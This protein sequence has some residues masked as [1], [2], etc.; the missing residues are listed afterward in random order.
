MT[1]LAQIVSRRRI[2]GE[3]SDEIQAHLDERIEELISAGMSRADASF[4]ARREF[5]NVTRTKETSSE[6]WRWTHFEDLMQDVR[7]GARMLRKSPGFT[8]IAILTLALGIGASTTVFS[9]VNSILL[10]PLPYPH[11][12]QIV[13]PWRITPPGVDLGFAEFP[14]D[15]TGY[16]LFAKETQTF[17]DT[18]AMEA[19]TFNLTGSGDPVRLN[20]VTVS[21]GF[22]PTLGVAPQVG[23]TF[24][25]DEDQLGH[26]REAVLSDALWR[27]QFG[28][29][30]GIAGRS[31]DLDGLSYAVIGVMPPGFA[32]PRSEEMPG[33]F[34]FPHTPQLWVPI[35]LPTGPPKRGEPSELAVIGRLKPGVSV[36]QAQAEMNIFTK[37]Q[38]ALIPAAKG[39]FN[40]RVTP[41]SRQV[42][43]DT[44]RPLLLILGA[45]GV[46]LLI[47][48]S[49]VAS[50]LL[51]RSLGRRKEF[52]VR[53][54]LGA[55]KGR[56]V[57]QLFTES[58]LL[59]LAAGVLGIAFAEAG[60]RFVRVMGP[61]DLPRLAEVSPDMRMFVFA[62][63]V[64][65]LTGI[66]F[67]IA[68]AFGAARED[69][70]GTLRETGQRS[71]GS[72]AAPRIRSILVVCEMALAL[73]LVIAAGLL[74]RTFYQILGVDA[75]FTAERALTFDISLSSVKYSDPDRI[76]T[77]YDKTLAQL[78]TIP[79]VRSAGISEAI[80]LRRPPEGTALR[81]PEF[82][83]GPSKQRPFGDYTFISP[84]YFGALGTPIL[85]GRD[86]L[87]S[88]T[89]DSTLV[90]IVNS[91]MAK[92]F[93]PGQDP[94]GKQV[95]V[96]IRPT[97]MTVVG[98][99]PDFRH[100]SL[101]ENAEPEIFVPY[102]QK[103]WPS[104]LALQVAVRTTGDPG[105]AVSYVREAIRAVDPGVPISNV[106]TM[107]A[108]VDDSM[109]QSRF[110]MLLLGS[111]GALALLMASIGMYGVISYAVAQRTREIAIRMALGAERKSVFTMV[112]AQGARLA[113]LGITIGV[114]V[115]LIA[116]RLMERFLFGVRPADPL[117]FGAV[118]TLLVAIALLASYVPARRAT[119]VD[120][121]VALRTE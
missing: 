99:V 43:G 115:A 84:G 106:M 120:P 117:T 85:R 41:L 38:E 11:A 65:L 86:F 13:L 71:G 39:W 20:G 7:F 118:I 21:A 28:A 105:A 76:L 102:T 31:I 67:G 52:T 57:R 72:V 101:R 14:W 50:L 113:A 46:V 68:P 89:G 58:L 78:R 6:V 79:Q 96:P 69:V 103:P 60:V 109:S 94:I 49:N 119:R 90:A 42:T 83:V 18:A 95:G 64:A 4:A 9:L 51:T 110:S 2:A 3:L 70:A 47:A 19:Q 104:M 91:T 10:N 59:A 37:R 93:W 82:V 81:V 24:T 55:G 73:V 98:V 33:N 92:R 75:G 15:R 45:V 36:A 87:D 48:C 112:L 23:R 116:T 56:L 30:P 80:P 121:M 97:N 8:A 5:G 100:K 40:T 34:E 16:L 53:A 66:L 114:A 26:E 108:A 27:Q 88:D 74:V 22:F 12:E 107:S 29:D 111:F 77:F 61:R 1:W 63:G 17:Q 62:L 54:A 35:A 25:S 32:F 44:R